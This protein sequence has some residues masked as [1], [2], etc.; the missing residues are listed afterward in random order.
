MFIFYV[1]KENIKLN[2][3]CTESSNLFNLKTT[4]FF[5]S[6]GEW[7]KYS[8]RNNL[9]RCYDIFSSE[10]AQKIKLVVLQGKKKEDTCKTFHIQKGL[11][12]KRYLDFTNPIHSKY[13]WKIHT[14][15]S[16][17]SSNNNCFCVIKGQY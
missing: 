5:L 6:Y 3:K 11:V 14:V 7:R 1:I 8:C 12:K 2:L 4:V 13:S 17:T 10:K 15:Y 9:V 16:Q